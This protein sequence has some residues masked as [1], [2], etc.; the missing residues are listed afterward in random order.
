VYRL[1]LIVLA[2]NLTAC[3]GG[4]NGGDSTPLDDPFPDFSGEYSVISGGGTFPCSGGGSLTIT[5]KTGGIDIT[6]DGVMIED[7]DSTIESGDWYTVKTSST[8]EGIIKR[9]GEFQL[10][11]DTEIIDNSDQE[12]IT[13]T[14]ILSGTIDLDNSSWGGRLEESRVHSGSTGTCYTDVAFTGDKLD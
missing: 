7:V 9:N 2:F 1:T 5:P 11:R 14:D 4:D 12:I 6:Q 10:R 3:G 8:Y 13:I